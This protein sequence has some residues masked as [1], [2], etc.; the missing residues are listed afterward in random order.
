MPTTSSYWCY[1]C[2]RF[3]RIWDQEPITCPDCDGGFL[4]QIDTPFSRPDARVVSHR[5]SR[6]FPAAAMYMMGPNNHHHHHHHQRT[7]TANGG[8]G[9]DHHHRSS[10]FNPVIVLRG[11]ERGGGSG[12]GYEL[13]YDDGG[14]SGL[15]P[16]PASMSEILLGA[17]FERLLE[18]LSQ[19]EMNSV[20]R[21]GVNNNTGAS[22]S[23]IQSMPTIQIDSDN[24]D[25]H[26]AV[27]KEAFELGDEAKEMPCKHIYHSDCILPW[28]SIRISC[29]VCR[30]ELPADL[31]VSELDNDSQNR[32]HDG[33]NEE[34]EVE[35]EQDPVGLTIWRLPGGGF[36]VGRFARRGGG[37]GGGGERE[38]PVVFTEMD[39]GFNNG[40][41]SRRVSWGVRGSGGRER[42]GFFGR[43]FRSMF[44]CFGGG[45]GG[46]GGLGYAE[47]GSSSDSRVTRGRRSRSLSLFNRRHRGWGVEIDSGRRWG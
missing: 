9:G 40:V 3:V 10:P 39:G 36:A 38:L 24:V 25:T 2:T 32:T 47:S 30:H 20:R 22:K 33:N 41:V 43:V 1:R 5:T 18:H 4:E 27:C 14:G 37:G 21:I 16:L 46:D 23:A 29:P 26:C 45:G 11:G 42:S 6:R 28:L 34:V 8:G 7:R 12:S 17:G 15:R 19:M 35:E 31:D 13:Y 44:G